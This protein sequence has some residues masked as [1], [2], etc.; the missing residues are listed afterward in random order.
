MGAESFI[1]VEF[2]PVNNNVNCY[3]NIY[4]ST[5]QHSR[6]LLGDI[7][8]TPNDYSKVT[9]KITQEFGKI[10]FQPIDLKYIMLRLSGN[11]AENAPRCVNLCPNYESD[12]LWREDGT[13]VIQERGY[14]VYQHAHFLSASTPEESNL[15][16]Q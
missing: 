1:K 14:R 12:K 3:L 4:H 13:M 8:L 2:T 7:E 16:K 15:G 11:Y 6:T 10:A 9:L 5:G